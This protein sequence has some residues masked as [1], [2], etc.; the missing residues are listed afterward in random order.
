MVDKEKNMKSGCNRGSDLGYALIMLAGLI[1]MSFGI[2]GTIESD[3]YL[4]PYLS[5]LGGFMAI[6]IIAH[7]IFYINTDKIQDNDLQHIIITTVIITISMVLL[8]I[9]C[10]IGYIIYVSPILLVILFILICYKIILDNN[11]GEFKSQKIQIF[12]AGQT[13]VVLTASILF[14]LYPTS[15]I[16]YC[17][18]AVIS[19]LAIAGA[20]LTPYRNSEDCVKKL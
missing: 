16:M 19:F 7:K 13:I 17:T 6:G 11:L 14:I 15:V 3:W 4:Q 9:L 8:L 5:P 2:L 20:F 1:T 12:S 10:T 18:I